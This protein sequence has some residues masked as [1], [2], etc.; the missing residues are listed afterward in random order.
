MKHRARAVA[1]SHLMG[2]WILRPTTVRPAIPA[3][4][5]D[6]KTNIAL[7]PGTGGSNPWQ[8][9]ISDYT[10]ATTHPK[11]PLEIE[12]G[13]TISKRIKYQFVVVKLEVP[14][15]DGAG[16]GAVRTLRAIVQQ[17]V[18][19]HHTAVVIEIESRQVSVKIAIFHVKIGSSVRVRHSHC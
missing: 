3:R 8:N 10:S 19:K 11:E 4:V 17:V 16:I 18:P 2:S 14:D 9:V 5:Q 12:F 1:L 13:V 6:A 15:A 7:M